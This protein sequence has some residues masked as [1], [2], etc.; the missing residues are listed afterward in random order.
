LGIRDKVELRLYEAAE[1]VMGLGT[2]RAAVAVDL[3]AATS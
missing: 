2:S 1:I 3:N